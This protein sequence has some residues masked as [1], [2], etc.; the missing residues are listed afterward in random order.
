MHDRDCADLLAEV[1][2]TLGLRVEGYR[3]VRAIVRKRLGR[4]LNE[5]RL[6]DRAAYRA[7]LDEHP[8]E[9]AV[10]AG[11]CLI[12]VS[13]FYRDTDVFEHIAQDVLPRLAR[14][15][16]AQG[17]EQV[18]VLSAGC[19]S[20]EEAYSIAIAWRLGAAAPLAPPRLETI[21]VDASPTMISRARL[22]CYPRGSFKELPHD[23]ATAALVNGDDGGLCIRTEIREGVRFVQGDLRTELPEG[24]FDLILCRNSAFTYFDL[25]TQ[26]VF[27]ER[28]CDSLRVFG[29]LVIG[30]KEELPGK[31]ER[32]VPVDARRRIFE[33]CS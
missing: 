24:P 8:D 3:R 7:Y 20:G 15:A 18:R 14:D 5:L 6:P 22:G 11:L 29:V 12:P 13:R 33:R 31:P 9:W 1:L 26:R 25:A 21:G 30:H 17:A 27:L 19:A 16:V 28:L 2:P 10:L 23:W 4:R 32:L